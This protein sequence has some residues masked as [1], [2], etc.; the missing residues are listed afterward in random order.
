MSLVIS[1]LMETM[2]HTNT[3]NQIMLDM[4]LP[5]IFNMATGRHLGYSKT[6]V[7]TCFDYVWSL[8]LNLVV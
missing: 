6:H 1:N 8:P 5:P 7:L 3:L 4:T 2:C